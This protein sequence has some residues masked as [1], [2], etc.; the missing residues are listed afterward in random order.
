MKIQEN[1]EIFEK[2]KKYL[3]LYKLYVK[4]MLSRLIFVSI[5]KREG[6]VN[7]YDN[8]SKLFNELEMLKKSTLLAFLNAM[9]MQFLMQLIYFIN[10]I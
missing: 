6:V 7:S 2:Y 8:G 9:F 4:L 10:I 1:A 3:K 5:V